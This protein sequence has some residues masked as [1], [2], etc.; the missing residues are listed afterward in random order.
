MPFNAWER[1]AFGVIFIVCGDFDLN[2]KLLP[3]RMWR[4]AFTDFLWCCW[5]I[6]G[7]TMTPS[8]TD[9]SLWAPDWVDRRN[10]R[11]LFG[12]R[13]IG[14][15]RFALNRWSWPNWSGRWTADRCFLRC[16]RTA[17]STSRECNWWAPR[18]AATKLAVALRLWNMWF[19]CRSWTCCCCDRNCFVDT[20]GI[21]AS[22]HLCPAL[23]PHCR[24]ARSVWNL[25]WRCPSP[26]ARCRLWFCESIRFYRS[27]V[28][29]PYAFSPQICSAPDSQYTWFGCREFR[30]HIN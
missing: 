26:I 1:L 17:H 10:R 22:P 21:P 20:V 23:A 29:I 12:L 8:R 7:P 6:A 5:I 9:Q 18:T 11:R 28:T 14:C 13:W 25:R 2:W 19:A 4:R 24:W 15:G 27:S 30:F 3:R 16:Q